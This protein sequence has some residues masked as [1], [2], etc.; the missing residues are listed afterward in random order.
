MSIYLY[1]PRTNISTPTTYKELEGITG[2]SCSTLMSYKSLGR[3]LKNINCYIIDDQTTLVQRKRMYAKEKYP[4]EYWKT[5]EGSDGQY[6]VSNYGRV[7]RIY[8]R[9][10]QFRMPYQRR[11]EGCLFVKAK[12]KGKSGDQRVSTMVAAH[13]VGPPKEGMVVWHKNGIVTDDFAG[14]LKYVTPTFL[15]KKTAF[16]AKSKPVTQLDIDTGEIIGEYRSA[17]EAG[18]ECFLSYQAILD[19]CNHKTKSSGGFVFMFT[20]EFDSKL[21]I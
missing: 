7:K 13:F 5:I 11:G 21:S 6:Q 17:R 2:K 19:N 16:K 9:T 8:K 3:K 12:Y 15:G 18:R 14:N 10:E 4:D 1:D 20:E